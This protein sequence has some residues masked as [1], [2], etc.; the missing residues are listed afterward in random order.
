MTD[1]KN[2]ENTENAVVA[3][4]LDKAVALKGRKAIEFFSNKEN[5]DGLIEVIKTKAT[6]AVF[7]MKKKKDRDAVGSIALKISQSR[8]V[9]TEASKASVADL[10]TQVK[11]TKDVNKHWETELNEIRRAVLAPRDEWQAKEDEIQ[12]ARIAK[13]KESIAGIHAIGVLTGIESKQDLANLID[14]VDTI[15]VAEGFEEFAQEA[16]QAA[17]DVLKAL[18]DQVLVIVEQDRK[19]EQDRLLLE[20][21]QRNA[22]AERLGKLRNI[23]MSVLGSS[24][25]VIQNKITSI[26]SV[27]LLEDE[28][29]ESL[30]EALNLVEVVIGQLNTM[31]DQ[32][33]TL[34][35]QAEIVAQAAIAAQAEPAQEIKPTEIEGVVTGSDLLPE[36]A[37]DDLVETDDFGHPNNCLGCPD[38]QG[39]PVSDI[40]EALNDEPLSSPSITNEIIVEFLEGQLNDVTDFGYLLVSPDPQQNAEAMANLRAKFKVFIGEK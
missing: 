13:I 36:V 40:V 30:V 29:G 27:E 9:V 33:I 26:E 5:I 4:S 10:N 3:I 23:P 39:I 37:S 14:A 22:I 6:T 12:E 15:D 7:D 28:F 32:A 18:N 34:E 17:K 2:T 31:L 16:A 24:A 38:C 1:I 8:K 20:A 19:A 25:A 35:E 21:N 11:A